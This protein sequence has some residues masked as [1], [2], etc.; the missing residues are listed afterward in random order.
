MSKF[1]WMIHPTRSLEMPSCSA[2]DLAE[3]RLSSKIPSYHI[4]KQV[5]LRTYQHPLLPELISDWRFYVYVI[6]KPTISERKWNENIILS[7]LQ[8]NAETQHKRL[9]WTPQTQ[10]SFVQYYAYCKRP[11]FA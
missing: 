8:W 4:G 1:S 3:I 9:Y 11:Y 10:P 7:H 2:I 6:F 5:V